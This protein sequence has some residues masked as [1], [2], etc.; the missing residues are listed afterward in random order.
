MK[1]LRLLISAAMLLV[2]CGCATVTETV[3]DSNQSQV[4]TRDIQ[5]RA[6]DTTD[7]EKML[8]VSIATLQDLGFVIDKADLELGSVTATKFVNQ[9][10]LKMSVTVR[11]RGT[12][13]LMVRANA[14]Y[15][16]SPVA[17]PEAYQSFFASLEKAA[18]LTAQEVD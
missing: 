3:L 14:Q 4:K 15:G 9:Q 2:L 1:P 17:T 16:L 5:T 7:K 13:Q 18:F 12:T 10:V 6:F 11:A 8:R